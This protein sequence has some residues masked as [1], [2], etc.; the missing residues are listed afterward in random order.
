M[1]DGGVYAAPLVEAG[2]S[3]EQLGMPRGRVTLPGIR[4]LYRTL[5]DRRPDV[6]QTWMYHADLVGGIVARVAGCRAVVWGVRASDWHEHGTSWVSRMLVRACASASR[7]VPSQIVFASHAGARVHIAAGYVEDRG[8]IIPN[9]FDIDRLLPDASA[10]SRQRAEWR[11]PEGHRLLGTVAR[12]DALK[13]HAMLADA[14]R[15]LAAI[16]TPWTAVWVGPGMMD[17]NADLVALL[18]RFALR[19]RVRLCGPSADLR[20]V[21]NALDVHVLSSRSEAFPNVLAE[22]MACGTPCVATDV[23]DAAL[24]VG[25]TGWVVP[26]RD[27]AAMTSALSDA[28]TAADGGAVWVRRQSACRQR[29]V[30]HFGLAAMVAAYTDV[31]QR[32]SAAHSHGAKSA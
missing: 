17:E 15:R 29:I 32:A 8:A 11:V 30:D 24:I 2:V 31:W 27:A 6:V 4:H 7:W 14:L 18:D 23:G 16:E 21:M 3:V 13:D 9:G 5:R 19:S 26:P 12:W 25:D 10:R 22:A 20:A 1:M 28:L